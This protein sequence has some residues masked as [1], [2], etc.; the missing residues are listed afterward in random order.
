[1]CDI[2]DMSAWALSDALARGEV[3]S[4]EATQ[5]YL[6]AIAGEDEKIGAYITVTAESALR[7]AAVTDR[8]R[9]AGDDLPRL[10]GVPA[11]VKDNIITSGVLTTCASRMLETFVPPY[12]AHVMELLDAQQTVMLGKLNMDEFA[13]GSTTENSAFKKTVNP[14]DITRVPGGSSGGSA[15]AV[16]ARTAVF[17]LGS[18]TGGSIRQPA[19]FCGTVGVKPTYG[20][21]S[22]YGLV[23]FASSL[24]QIG[25]LTRDVRDAAL[26]LNAIVG[27]DLRDSTSLAHV[28]DDFTEGLEGGVRGMRIALPKEY[29][30]EGLSPAISANIM[31]AAHMY[32]TMGAEVHEV[33][34]P[35]LADALPA[36]YIISSA[37]ASSNLARF[38]GVKYGMRAEAYDDV[39]ALYANTRGMG[40]GPEVKRRIMLGTFALS[41]GYYDAYYAKALAV[42]TRVMRDFERIFEACDVIL[43]PVT[44]STAYKIGDHID[45]PT[46]MYMG[47]IYTVPVNIAGLPAISIP[48]GTDG[49]LPVGMQ[50]VGRAFDEKTL[51]RAARAYELGRGTA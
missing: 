22:R 42:R 9:A 47:D 24:D 46:A 13:M 43:S 21:V 14:A 40:F 33:T 37:E 50:L 12:D 19:A 8:H 30:G 45:D 6:D 44:P 29:F 41:A 17:T 48:C 7:A 38:D 31:N 26:V 35:S 2:R 20:A 39:D 36:Y 34:M 28:T 16:A 25:P 5:C 3:S 51:L 11:A 4:V 10:A 49:G 1:M 15:A 18:D 32:E 23:A 27:R